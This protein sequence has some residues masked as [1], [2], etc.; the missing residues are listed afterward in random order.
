ML[1]RTLVLVGAI[2][3]LVVAAPASAH[4]GNPNFRSILNAATPKVPGVSFSVI[5][6]DSQ[7]QLINKSSQPVTIFGYDGEPYARVLP[8]GSVE[9]NVLSPATYLNRDALGETPVPKSANAKAAPKWQVIN[10]TGRFAWHDHRMHWMA[11]TT[12]AKVKDKSKK[13]R[14]F[15]YTIPVSVGAKKGAIQGTL[16]WVGEPSKAPVGAIVGL[17]VFVALS[18]TLVVVV[19]RRRAAADG[20]GESEGGGGPGD[21]AATPAPGR[22]AEE[23]W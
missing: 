5:G 16:F 18:A 3:T 8:D 4:Q 19:R 14:V 22:K 11:R 6:Y 17:V 12:P 23:A 7:Y 10:K 9:Q 21:P 15:N 1:R 2:A 13:T 20:G